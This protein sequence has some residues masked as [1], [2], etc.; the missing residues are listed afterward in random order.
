MK[1][2][3]LDLGDARTGVAL[4]DELKFLAQSY[5]TIYNKDKEDLLNQLEP[6][7]KENNVET[8]VIGLPK[9]MNGTIGERGEMAKDFAE[10]LKE[11]FGIKT[12]MWDERLT[13]VSAHRVLSEANVRGK[14]RK[15]VVDTVSAVFI[16]QCYL[17]SL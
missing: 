14:K 9:N 8:V 16:L 7:I 10:K 13:T 15:K 2:M 11:R 17:D 6:V 4:S 3:G 12:V 1:V 5:G